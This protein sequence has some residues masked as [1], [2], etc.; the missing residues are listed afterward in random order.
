MHFNSPLSSLPFKSLLKTIVLK[1]FSTPNV[2]NNAI[3]HH[4]FLKGEIFD[5][6]NDGQF[7]YSLW[8]DYRNQVK[9][10]WRLTWPFQLYF[11]LNASGMLQDSEQ[12]FL[13]TL[14]QSRTY[15]MSI[16]EA[17]SQI[18]PYLDKL[19]EHF[20][21]T[22]LIDEH[23]QIPII[24]KKKSTQEAQ[25]IKNDKL[26]TAEA[27]FLKISTHSN[28]AI[29]NSS[30]LEIGC[31]RA[32]LTHA[33][34]SIGFK[35]SVGIDTTTAGYSALNKIDE[36]ENCFDKLA[37]KQINNIEETNFNDSSFDVICSISVL[38]HIKDLKKA[39]KEMYR[40]LKPGGI[41]YHY[42]DPF[43]SHIGGHSLCILDFPWGHSRLSPT[44][45]NNYVKQFRPHEAP[46]AK[47]FYNNLFNT[48]R[49]TLAQIQESFIETGFQICQW[50][51]VNSNP[52]AKLLTNDIFQQSQRHYPD[53]QVRDF[54]TH[55]VSIIMKK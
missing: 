18:K 25:A 51:E 20:V 54:I 6:F 50:E 5:N 14:N 55:G 47:D 35:K 38:E 24:R 21:D 28:K 11:D 2:E 41:A 37:S 52:H 26:R 1:M 29:E 19:P 8:N 33:M 22:G 31:G 32:Y 30:F 42:F 46:Y 12:M 45:F 13:S 49:M 15:P 36:V 3:D 23:A 17:F 10:R 43:F 7:S 53:I 16:K 27:I 39:I 44:H 9:N 4:S 34:K 48:P 40:I